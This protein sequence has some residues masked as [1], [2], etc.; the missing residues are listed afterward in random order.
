MKFITF[1]FLVLI[2]LLVLWYL[3]GHR[4]NFANEKDL[5]KITPDNIF[6]HLCYIDNVLTENNIKHWIMYGTLL[7]AIRDND[8]IQHDYDFD[9]GANIE[10]RNKILS[11]N[12]QVKKDGYSLE[13]QSLY[14][15][16]YN[17][18]KNTKA[19]WRI[20]VKVI[21]QGIEFGDIYLYQ[22]FNDGYMRRFNVEEGCYFWPN[23]TYPSVFTDKLQLLQ[24]RNKEFNAP[25]DAEILLTHWYGTT[26][27]TPYKAPA[28]GGE[29]REGSDYFGGTTTVKLANLTNFVNN[30]YGLNLKPNLKTKI[31]Y[32][33][34]QDQKQ[35]ILD[36]EF[37][38]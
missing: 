8:I 37:C 6:Y 19:V 35:W 20:S 21:Y 24:I 14:Q 7:G 2:I 27:K 17:N 11:L 13:L 10:D 29:A 38:K 18:V 12:N 5:K 26:W 23:S 22:K 4:E 34:P 16:E 3:Y 28:Q 1:I 36:N 15:N 9:F 30:K 25:I 32:F 31:N 33:Y